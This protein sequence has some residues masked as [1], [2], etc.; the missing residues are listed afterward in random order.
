[1]SRGQH[2]YNDSWE[3]E[4]PWLCRGH[5]S[6][7]AKCTACNTSFSIAHG[8]K[9]HIVSHAKG[10]KH[11]A[12][13][14]KSPLDIKSFF[15]SSVSTATTISPSP[16]V[17]S[18]PIAN[19]PC[20]SS[21]I[22][23]NEWQGFTRKEEATRAELILTMTAAKLNI[24]ARSIDQ[25]VSLLPQVF[26]DSSIAQQISLGRTKFSYYLT[27]GLAPYFADLLFRQV[28]NA[29]EYVVIFDESLNKVVQKSQMDI[30]VRFWSD[31]THQV[32]TRYFS[33]VFLGRTRAEDLLQA[34]T[35]SLK[36]IG[37]QKL[38]SVS[39]DGPNVN[40]SFYSQLSDLRS[41][42]QCPQLLI[43]GTC[44]LHIVHGALLNGHRSSN[45]DLVAILQ[46]AYYL[47]KDSPARRA[48]YIRI[49]GNTSFPLKCCSIRW[50]ENIR[51]T[52]R[53]LQI[54]PALTKYVKDVSPKPTIGSFLRLKNALTDNFIK[55]KFAFF[56]SV[57]NIFEPFL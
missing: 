1:M 27:F 23:P 30:L 24:S 29:P 13:T 12:K 35:K 56:V 50:C 16:P 34:F 41:I 36:D 17:D 28:K 3:G 44:P 42:E 39:M 26:F 11:I 19:V 4:F 7:E 45:W 37:L 53:F 18:I 10:S 6:T 54:L 38:L 21:P 52:Q 14:K 46:A 32:I 57:G 25:L 9:S 55:A 33:S 22:A 15:I 40:L 47:F 48:E 8:G 51:V 5:I 2:H 20:S 43:T 31:E 49:T